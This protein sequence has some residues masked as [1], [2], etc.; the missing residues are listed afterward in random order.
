MQPSQMA[1]LLGL[2]FDPENEAV[3]LSKTSNNLTGG[4]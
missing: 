2:L 3:Y 1:F 4:L